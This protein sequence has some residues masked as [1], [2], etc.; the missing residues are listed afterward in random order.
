MMRITLLVMML[1]FGMSVITPSRGTDH[2]REA[3]QALCDVLQ[4]AV[5]TWGHHGEGLSPPLRRTL[6]ETLF[7]YGSPGGSV[8]DLRKTWPTDY[9]DTGGFRDYY[10]GRP[11]SSVFPRWPGYSAP[12]DLLCLC[13]PGEKGY[14]VNNT[15]PGHT[16]C[17]KTRD[18]LGGGTHGWASSAQ[19]ANPQEGHA[20]ITATW[21][22]V[23]VPCLQP[24]RKDTPLE[25]ALTHFIR[26]L[27]PKSGDT[28]YPHRKQLG[29]GTPSTYDGCTGVYSP[30]ICVMYYPGDRSPRNPSLPQPWWITLEQALRDDD[31]QDPERRV[32]DARINHSEKSETAAL[33]PPS[34]TETSPEKQSARL[35]KKHH[36]HPHHRPHSG[37]HLLWPFSGV[38]GTVVLW[39]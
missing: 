5:K 24:P 9:N 35:A 15:H 22:N 38:L 17:G 13:V 6:K 19:G 8:E 12:H 39:L 32:P 16:L 11:R 23:T 26:H 27:A 30:G 7:G 10:C 36:H 34:P 37:A 20:S 25:A 29:E 4:A 14:P 18:A 1:G 3:Y 33:L 2:N 28:N 31:P 21:W